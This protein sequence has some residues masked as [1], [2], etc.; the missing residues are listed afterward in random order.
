[1]GVRQRILTMHFD[2]LKIFVTFCSVQISP[3]ETAQA[4]QIDHHNFALPLP[5]FSPN[6]AFHFFNDEI[7]KNNLPSGQPRPLFV[8]FR[9]F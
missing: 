7:L 6:R 5:T 1:M 8:Y 2:V 3:V 4:A 9:S